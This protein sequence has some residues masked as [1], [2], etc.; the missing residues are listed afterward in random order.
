MNN[1]FF[2]TALVTPM[3]ADDSLHVDGLETV[4]EQQLEAGIGGLLLGGSMG[5]MQLLPHA[6]YRDLMT[7]GARIASGRAELLGGAGD[8]SLGLTVERLEFLNTLPLDGVVV[9]PPYVMP[10]DQ[11]ELI[12][13]YRALADISKT[14][15]FLYD[16]PVMTRSK[17]ALDTVLTLAQHPNIAGIKCSD[18]PGFGRQ[19]RDETDPSFRVLLAAPTLIDTLIPGG[20]REHLDGVYCLCPHLMTALGR[21]AA[22][23]DR[24]QAAEYQG[25][26]NR[27]LRLLHAHG[28]WRPATA[29]LNHLGVA[30]HF[31]PRPHRNWTETESQDFLNQPGTQQVL[32]AVKAVGMSLAA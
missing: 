5:T 15:L 2:C 11:A 7:E 20:F 10:Y 27:L 13:Y 16:L 4:I 31:K 29:I 1:P 14:P 18:E 25:I 24:T 12:D 17:I 9:L 6:T 3:H 32:E 30:G 26:L 21:A 22:E 19:V 28:V 8:A 23:G